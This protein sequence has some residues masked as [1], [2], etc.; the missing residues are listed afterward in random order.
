MMNQHPSHHPVQHKQGFTLIELL[1]VISIVALLI[2]ILLPALAKARQASWNVVCINQLK[3]LG[4]A[5][6]IYQSDFKD[7]F[8]L[9]GKVP[10]EVVTYPTWDGRMA[11]Y[12]S[13]VTPGQTTR[14]LQCPFDRRVA[15]GF[16]DA[17]SYVG[18]QM[19]P[20]T[21]GRPDEG[22]IWTPTVGYEPVKQNDVLRPVR[23]VFLMELYKPASDAGGNK[24]WGYN[25]G[26]TT[27]WINTRPNYLFHGNTIGKDKMGFLFV[28][29]HVVIRDPLEAGLG[30]TERWWY[31]K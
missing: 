15:E 12:L 2:S 8:P 25:Y 17:K 30:G 26:A 22:V 24:Q 29:G 27:G 21:A 13:G 9:H 31:R 19:C 20:T 28:D 10:G 3:S 18:N 23:T 6:A 16:T 7:L 11:G 4:V 1:V 5:G 14:L